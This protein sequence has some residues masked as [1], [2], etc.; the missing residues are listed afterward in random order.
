MYIN[1]LFKPENVCV[2]FSDCLF[3]LCAESGSEELRC[4]SYEAYATACQN[5]G[6]KLGPWRQQLSCG[7]KCR[8]KVKVF[9]K[10]DFSKMEV[11]LDA[12]KRQ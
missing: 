10:K 11:V 6:I 3:D 7:K 9:F 12:L 5:E 1:L 8:M 2:S 4:A